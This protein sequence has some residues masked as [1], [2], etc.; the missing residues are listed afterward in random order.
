MIA[1]IIVKPSMRITDP[2]KKINLPNK[3]L[4]TTV[5]F[6]RPYANFRVPLITS[7]KTMNQGAPLAKS[8]NPIDIA[9]LRSMQISCGD[10]QT[11]EDAMKRDNA[12]EWEQAAKVEIESIAAN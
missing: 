5:R 9:K 10:P 4:S 6:K 3:T 2:P 8:K 11:F 12:K 7:R 1:K